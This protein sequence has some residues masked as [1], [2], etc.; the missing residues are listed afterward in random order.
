M[1]KCIRDGKL[2]PGCGTTTR[3][4]EYDHQPIWLDLCGRPMEG[5][6]AVE[7]DRALWCW[8]Y[9]VEETITG[10]RSVLVISDNLAATLVVEASLGTTIIM[11]DELIAGLDRQWGTNDAP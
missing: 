2:A 8:L 3:I 7:M 10:C 11:R 9:A 5:E 6:D 1:A 4:T